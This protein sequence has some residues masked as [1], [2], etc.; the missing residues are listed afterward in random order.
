MWIVNADDLAALGT[1]PLF[2]LHSKEMLQAVSPDI[3]KVVDHAHAILCPVALIQV[4]QPGAGEAI[5]TEAVWG[6]GVGYS[7]AILDLAGHAGFW[8]IDI[9]APAARARLFIS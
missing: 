1:G 2:R 6:L 8:F 9:T 3:L 7:L 4:F 5:T